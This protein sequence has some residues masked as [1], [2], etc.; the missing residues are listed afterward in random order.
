MHGQLKTVSPHKQ[1]IRNVWHF[2][3]NSLVIIWIVLALTTGIY[4]IDYINRLCVKQWK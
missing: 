2:A 4:V 3:M 1:A